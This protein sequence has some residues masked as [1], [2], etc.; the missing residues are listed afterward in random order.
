MFSKEQNSKYRAQCLRAKVCFW[1]FR[2]QILRKWLIYVKHYW[3]KCLEKMLREE[4]K[5]QIL[6]P[7]SSSKSSLFRVSGSIS[8]KRIDWHQPILIKMIAKEIEWKTRT[9]NNVPTVFEQ[10]FVFESFRLHFRENVWLTSNKNDQIDLKRCGVKNKTANIMPSVFEQKFAF[11][12]FGLHFWKNNWFTSNTNDQIDWKRYWVK[13][14]NSKYYTRC[15]R[16]KVRFSKFQAPFL[17]KSLIDI[18]H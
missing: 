13:N 17:R 4:Q 10:K 7:F 9:A 5:Q 14:K 12:S 3:S 11:E 2:L 15:L 8:E 6:Y 1:E 16:A 18:K